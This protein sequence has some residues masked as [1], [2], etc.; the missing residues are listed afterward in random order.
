MTLTADM[1][2]QIMQ[3]ADEAY[4]DY[5]YTGVRFEI[6]SRGIGD[7]CDNSKHNPDRCDERDFPA[8]GSADYNSLDELDGTSAWTIGRH[9]VGDYFDD[10]HCY[11]I[12][13]DS[14]G[15]HDD[16]DINEILLQDPVVIAQIF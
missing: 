7:V 14:V 1:L 2:N 10:M 9:L 6:K 3:L 16:P 4:D 11:L 15:Y 8:Y 13:S 5:T 12:G